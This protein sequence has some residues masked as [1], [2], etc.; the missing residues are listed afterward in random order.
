MKLQKVISCTLM[1]AMVC[2][3][4]ACGSKE[5]AA[6]PAA[7][8]TSDTVDESGTTTEVDESIIEYDLTMASAASAEMYPNVAM[9]MGC[10]EVFENRL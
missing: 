10:N 3:L 9:Q 5:G 2:S 4:T 6:T 1:A 8:N 7:D